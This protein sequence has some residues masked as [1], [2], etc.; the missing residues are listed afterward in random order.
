MTAIEYI[1]YAALLGS[2]LPK[3]LTP[4]RCPQVLNVLST[5]SLTQ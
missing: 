4:D 5:I 3:V 1:L 2:V